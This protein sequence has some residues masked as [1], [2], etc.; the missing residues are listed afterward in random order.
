MVPV[1][2]LGLLTPTLR[3][4]SS[5]AIPSSGLFHHAPLLGVIVKMGVC[6]FLFFFS[7]WNVL[8]YLALKCLFFSIV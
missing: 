7:H 5:V 2:P 3:S 8:C 6:V 1:P 4:S